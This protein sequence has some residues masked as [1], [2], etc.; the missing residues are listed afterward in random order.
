MF[1]QKIGIIGRTYRHIQRYTEILGIL[2]KFGFGDLVTSLKVEQYLDIGRQ[3]I[4]REKKETIEALTR[5]VRLRMVLEELGPTFIKLGQMLSTRADVLPAE[6]IKE[7]IKLQDEVPPFSFDDAKT[8]IEAEL[9]APLATYYSS[10]NPVPLAAASIG[11][12][13]RAVTVE[14]EEVVIKVQRPGIKK[15]IEVDLEIMLHLAT[16]VERH[17]DGGDLHRPTDLVHEFGQS[18]ERELDYLTEAGNMERLSNMYLND[19]RVYVPKVLREATTPR[20]LTMEYVDGIQA[21]NM[22]EL[23]EK[24]HDLV[25]IARI[26]ADLVIDQTMV[27]GFF[28]ADPHPGNLL[29]LPGDVICFLDM[30]MMGRLE[31]PTRESIIDLV[32]GVVHQDA[33]AL[34][35]ALLRIT[36]WDDEPDRRSLGRTL[37]SFV[38]QHINRPLKE[39]ELGKVLQQVFDITV[40]YRLRLPS[41]LLLLVKALT[42]VEGLGRRLDPDFD[43]IAIAA[44][45]VKRIQ[46]QRY[47]PGRLAEDFWGYAVETVG[48]FKELPGEVRAVLRLA[49]QGRL[50]VELEHVALDEMRLTQDRASNRLSFAI[51]LASLIIGSSMIIHSGI[52]PTWHGIPLIGLAGYLVA[53]VMGFWLLITILRRG[54]M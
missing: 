18:L 52:P 50:R 8:I 19:N 40:K 53:G 25:A 28:H 23:K 11:Q 24:G 30:G 3:M 29:I 1:I 48:I 16:L 13:H 17:L 43:I 22:A 49:R 46:M 36:E 37:T 34:V 32:I 39:I 10:V 47:H 35:N 12:V 15:S 41:D 42:A 5:A 45:V 33:S 21:G 31:R 26:G 20:I 54:M 44:P 9:N 14:G 4:F 2:F 6:F 7:L 38:D 27:H 51:V